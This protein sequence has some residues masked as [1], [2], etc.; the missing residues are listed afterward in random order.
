MLPKG[1][2]LGDTIGIISPA[3]TADEGWVREACRGIRSQGFQTVTAPNLFQKTWGYAA[4]A[5]E[6][7]A[8][9]HAMLLNDSVR[10]ILFGGGEVCEEILPS[11]DFSLIQKHPKIICSYSDSTTLLDAIYFKTGLITFYG[12]SPKTFHKLTDYNRAQFFE[13]LTEG[14]KAGRFRTNSHWEVLRSG[15]GEGVLL[16]GYLE[17]FS[18][19]ADGDYWPRDSARRYLLFLEDHFRF[20]QPAA[21]AR[22]LARIE[23][24]NLARQ[25]SGLIF[26]HYSE[27]K[28]PSCHRF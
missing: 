6:R 10:M 27:K 20:H 2:Q 13:R 18:L 19:L 16:G 8:D 26:G 28:I 11:I 9:F 5:E 3:G 4:S 14:K 17:N 12:A 7:T 23:Q 1:L 22:Y 24:S 21:V 25:V 15:K